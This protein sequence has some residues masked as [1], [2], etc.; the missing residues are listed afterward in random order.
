MPRARACCSLWPR[1]LL[2]W[3]APQ[4]GSLRSAK[5]EREGVPQAQKDFT[6]DLIKKARERQEAS[7]ASK[8]GQ[9]S[10][11]KA[12]EEEKKQA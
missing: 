1:D 2:T 6:A 7:M 3:R 11:D 4:A 12:T 5:Q 9:P 10:A 8:K